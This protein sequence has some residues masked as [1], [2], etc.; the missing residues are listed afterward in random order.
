MCTSLFRVQ[1][2]KTSKPSFL[3]A[4]TVA[5]TIRPC[6]CPQVDMFVA[7]AS[8]TLE[9]ARAALDAALHGP[10]MEAAAADLAEVASALASAPRR[11]C[12]RLSA[13]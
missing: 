4:S 10:H 6:A 7:D 5:R 8:K 13:C 12:R 3:L 11:V 1:I 9:P 2:L